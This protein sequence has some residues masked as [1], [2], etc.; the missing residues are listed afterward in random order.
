MKYTNKHKGF[1]LIELMIVIAIIGILMAYAIPAYQDYT[2]RTLANEGNAMAASYKTAVTVAFAELDTLT[3]IDNSTGHIPAADNIGLCVNSVTVTDGVIV[4]RYNCAAGSNGRAN[5]DVD[6][7]VLTWT[8]TPTGNSGSSLQWG[9]S[10]AP[11]GAAYDP[12][13]K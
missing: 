4:V 6:A 3:G 13:P 5:T 8:P 9:C 12:C 10:Y 7:G 2:K 11:A 1:T